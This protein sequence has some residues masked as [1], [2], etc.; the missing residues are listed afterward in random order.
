M[1]QNENEKTCYLHYKLN[2]KLKT[3]S[4]VF[5]DWNAGDIV[6][7]KYNVEDILRSSRNRIYIFNAYN[8]T[9]NTVIELSRQN[10]NVFYKIFLVTQLDSSELVK[11]TTG[12]IKYD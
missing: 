9:T 1:D 6:T 3:S 2:N 4:K 7:L 5:N 10:I 8:Y 12:G 11:M